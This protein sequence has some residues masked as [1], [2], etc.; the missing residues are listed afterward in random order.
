[1]ATSSLD[2]IISAKDRV[3]GTIPGIRKE[4][5]S[6]GASVTSFKGMLVGGLAGIGLGLGIKELI[7]AAGESEAAMSRFR[8]SMRLVGADSNES[9]DRAA[10]FATSV[11]G[12]TTMGDEAVLNIMSLGSTLTGLSGGPLEEATT[13]AIGLSKTLGIDA[14]GAMRL[15]AKGVN[16]NFTAFAKY[17]I[18]LDETATNQ[19]KLD[20]VMRRGLDGFKL[21]QAEAETTEGRLTQMKEVAGDVAE[22]IGGLLLP[23][24]KMIATFLRDNL[25]AIQ[26]WI[27]GFND[28]ATDAANALSRAWPI[29]KLSVLEF[30]DWTVSTGLDFA[31]WFVSLVPQL[32]GAALTLGTSLTEA[33]AG[34]WDSIWYGAQ[35]AFAKIVDGLESVRQAAI[36]TVA[37]AK[38][39]SDF[40]DPAQQKEAI[41][42]YRAN[43]DKDRQMQAGGLNDQLAEIDKRQAE[44]TGLRT[45]LAESNRRDFQK[46]TDESVKDLR[47][48]FANADAF[49]FR[50]TLKLAIKQATDELDKQTGIEK[51]AEK[52]AS[53]FTGDVKAK[54]GKPKDEALAKT[55]AEKQVEQLAGLDA[56]R[57]L[58]GVTA[59]AKEKASIYEQMMAEKADQQIALAKEQAESQKRIADRLA[60]SEAVLVGL[61]GEG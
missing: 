1:M 49:G 21:A 9:A 19:E 25:P 16:G 24:V 13:A 57:F 28:F 10:K 52:L 36:D 48:G 18:S 22:S 30:V 5:A 39:R 47:D 6:L 20:T 60:A 55:K 59:A 27:A 7:S 53:K 15:L 12:M 29:L 46:R 33:F 56:S 2:I 23:T 38:I 34:V 50:D 45:N 14:E 58:T 4:I 11:Q 44:S 40:T 26:E 43:R 37:E 31:G 54:D 51:P 41:D 61:E 3:T 17:G 42:L 8:A 35:R 32:I